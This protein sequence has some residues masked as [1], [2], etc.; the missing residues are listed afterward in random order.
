[1]SAL[2]ACDSSLTHGCALASVLGR[3]LGLTSASAAVITI[4]PRGLEAAT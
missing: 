2:A 1:M 4:Y 3:R